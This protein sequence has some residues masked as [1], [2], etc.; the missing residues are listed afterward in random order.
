MDEREII[1]RDIKP[2]NILLYKPFT[3]DLNDIYV[4][5]SDFGSSRYLID[6]TPPQSPVVKGAAG[7]GK[8]GGDSDGSNTVSSAQD[9]KEMLPKH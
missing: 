9:V 6:R 2:E 7:S 1:H 8:K 4:K 5:L 3:K